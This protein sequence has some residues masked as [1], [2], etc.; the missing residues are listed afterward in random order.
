MADISGI[1]T[2]DQLGQLRAAWGDPTED[3]QNRTAQQRFKIEMGTFL[4]QIYPLSGALLEAIKDIFY[5]DLPPDS[6]TAPR[7]ALSEMD[8]E[9]IIVAVLAGREINSNIGLHMYI[10]LVL[11]ISPAEI[12]H[13]LLLAGVYSG[14][15]SFADGVQMEEILL[16]FLAGRFT[17]G[18]SIK[19]DELFGEMKATLDD[20]P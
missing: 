12:A 5:G 3:S 10:A 4:P 15:P 19:P 13:I 16:T 9:R 6:G 7:S 17:R 20:A 18:D 8:R 11:G 14:I 1:L 2:E